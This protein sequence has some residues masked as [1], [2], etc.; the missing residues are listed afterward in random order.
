MGTFS[1]S[2]GIVLLG[3]ILVWIDYSIVQRLS[4]AQGLLL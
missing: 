3:S 1:Q 2:S 4:A